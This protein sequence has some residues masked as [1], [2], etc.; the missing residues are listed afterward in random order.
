MPQKLS[1]QAIDSS[2]FWIE[3][4][5]KETLQKHGLLE[6]GWKFK[7]D[8]AKQRLGSCSHSRK[9]ITFSMYYTHISREEIE[10][11][12]LHEIAHALIGP[13]HGHNFHWK[14]KAREIGAK[15]ERLAD[16]T[17]KTSAKHNYVIKCP[18]CGWQVQR[19][20][21]KRRNFGSTCPEC[22][23]EVKIY[24]YVRKAASDGK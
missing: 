8:N 1:F 15:P 21:M 19:H 20:R 5:A 10:D 6:L 2:E 14:Q 23:T 4:F 17:I 18:N 11:T 24:K 7:F 13:E 3:D 9:T 12:I 16:P 22:R